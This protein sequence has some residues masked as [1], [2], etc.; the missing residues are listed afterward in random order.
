MFSRRP[1]AG[2]GISTSTL[3]VVTSASVSSASTQSPGCLRHSRIVPS[4][5][6]MP[7][8]GIA[9]VTSEPS[10]D[11]AAPGREAEEAGGTLVLEELIARLLHVFELRQDGLLERGAER[12]RDVR[13]GEPPHRRVQVLEGLGGHQSSD[14]RSYPARLRRLVGDQ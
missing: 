6:E 13:S 11:P 3:S 5:T 14:L 2:D 9:T 7:I 8:F 4:E 10:A 12:D 1:L